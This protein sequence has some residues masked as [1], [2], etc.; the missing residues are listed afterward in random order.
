M[1]RMERAVLYARVSGDGQHKEGT[2][3]SQI[4]ELRRQ[5]AAAGRELVKEYI[6]DGITRTIMERPALEQL[7]EDAKTDLFDRIYFHAADRI[8]REAAHQNVIIS[9]LLKRSKQVTIGGN[10]YEETPEGKLMLNLLGLFSEYERAKIAERM[11][12][13]RLYR[14]RMGQLSSN[15]HRTYGYHYIKKTPAAPATLVI[16]EEQAAIVRSIFEM[17][18][19]G[20]YGLVTIC[21]HLEQQHILTRTGRRQ[22][23]NDRVKTM[24]KNET[25][26]GVRYFNR[27]TA[28]TE[29]NRE[30]KQVIRGKWVLRD[31]SEW[32]A[33]KVPAIVPRELFDKAQERLRRHNERYCQ[34]VTRYLL[35]GLVQCGVCGSG[36]SSS[37]RYHKVK[38]PSGNVSVYHRSVYRRGSH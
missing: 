28:A 26:V 13:G 1:E 3:E 8:A 4:A 17:F 30:G 6:D 16:N 35:S 37:R 5:I 32:I 25:Y 11:T 24:L 14:L 18:A 33:V 21:R 29:A 22:W 7:R 31:P 12:R 23:D 34:P 36:C 10:D 2:I 38:R 27:I 9:E 15:G 20:Q 19:T